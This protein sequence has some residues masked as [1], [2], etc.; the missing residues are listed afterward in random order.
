MNI[1]SPPLPTNPTDPSH[2]DYVVEALATGWYCRNPD[3]QVW[4]G[5]A[6][7][8]LLAC[9]ACGAPRPRR[10]TFPPKDAP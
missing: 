8:F 3:C 5:D 10:S 9:R 4:C 2:H 1:P 6:K 7:V